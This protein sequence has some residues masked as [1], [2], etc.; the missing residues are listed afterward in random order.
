MNVK[1]IWTFTIT[2]NFC[3]YKCFDIFPQI[4]LIIFAVFRYYYQYLHFYLS[5]NN[6]PAPILSKKGFQPKVF[7]LLKTIYLTEEKYTFF[8]PTITKPQFDYSK[9][10]IFRWQTEFFLLKLD[11]SNISEMILKYCGKKIWKRS[12]Q[13]MP[14]SVFLSKRA[15][16]LHNYV[17]FSNKYYVF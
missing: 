10:I 15:S 8:H 11:Y 17:L 14:I 3:H 9:I 6:A 7:G 5:L 1:N 4:L 12:W 16:K 2:Y 13:L